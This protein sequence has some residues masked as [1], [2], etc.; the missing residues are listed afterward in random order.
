MNFVVILAGGVG[1]RMKLNIPKQYLVINKK[2]V[3]IHTILNFENNPN[4][5]GIIVVCDSSY[6]DYLIKQFKKN[7]IKKFVSF[8]K[9]GV[10]GFESTKNGILEAS[11]YINKDDLV[12][13]H[14]AVR[15][16]INDFI[17]NDMIKTA[18]EKGN[19]CTSTELRETLLYT[20]DGISSKRSID[21]S[22][23][24]KVQTPQA[25]KI[26]DAIECYNRAEKLNIK[27]ATYINVLMLQVG[28]QIYFSSGSNLNVKLT[29]PEDLLLFKNYLKS[30][31]K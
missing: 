30:I 3:I 29:T 6:N 24:R 18:V 14:D 19:S 23:V 13:I 16:I 15:P 9:A 8:A 27:D 22:V 11:K 21:R 12:V 17:I 1:S 28:Y 25:Y 10:T 4:I 7:N 26:S 2:P 20:E 31:K 5:D